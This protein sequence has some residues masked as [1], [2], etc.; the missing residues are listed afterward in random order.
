MVLVTLETKSN[1]FGPA[2]HPRSPMIVVLGRRVVYTS[3]MAFSTTGL[4][5]RKI[6]PNKIHKEE[7]IIR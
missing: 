3:F 1:V 7:E 4:V 2:A 5:S 6:F